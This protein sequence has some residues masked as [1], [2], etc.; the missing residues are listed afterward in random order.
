[1]AKISVSLWSADLADLGNEVKRLEN[2]ADLF[3]F[4]VADGHFGSTFIFSPDLIKA[5]R[6]KTNIPFDAHLIVEHPDR[7][8]T[9]FIDAGADIITVYAESDCDLESTIKK[10]KKQRTK[11]A[12]SLKPETPVSVLEPFLDGLDMVLIMGAGIDVKGQAL[13]PSTYDKIK[14]LASLIAQRGLSI[15]IGIDGGVSKD[16][17]PGL[18]K[19]GA[20]VVVSGTLI[21]SQ[22]P[23]VIFDWLKKL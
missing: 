19:A 10:I 16:T 18:V 2:Y 8:I 17:V 20:T 22:E 6:G 4:D 7:F 15:D 9:P 5:L 23:E 3:H 21:F 12:V 11:V 13:V 1:M 14:G